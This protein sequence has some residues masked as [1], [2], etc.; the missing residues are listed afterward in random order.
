MRALG[1]HGAAHSQLRQNLRLGGGASLVVSCV[2]LASAP[3]ISSVLLRNPAVTTTLRLAAIASVLFALRRIQSEALKAYGKASLAILIDSAFLAL[4][5]LAATVLGLLLQHLSVRW[6]LWSFVALQGVLVMV[7]AAAWWRTIRRAIHDVARRAGTA[8]VARRGLF[9]LWGFAI[10]SALGTE[11]P[12]VLLP[13][14]GSAE[15]VGLFGV[16]FR[17]VALATTIL[18]AMASSFGPSF[19]AAFV[20]R[21]ATALRRDLLRSQAISAL[22][23]APMAAAFLGAPTFVLG[24]FGAEFHGA[25]MLLAI[26]TLGQAVDAATGLSGTLLNMSG[27]ERSALG[28]TAVSFFA[29]IPLSAWLGARHGAAGIAV[30]YALVLATRSLALYLLALRRVRAVESEV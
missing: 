24:L 30:A 19:S 26:L 7:G 14:Y 10:V 6:V 12:F 25:R 9:P 20:Q 28:V 22:L 23:Y 13:R 1:D 27:G 17:L 29:L 4:G 2:V 8:V 16:A 3:W 21:D 18:G 5:M 11:L 15:D